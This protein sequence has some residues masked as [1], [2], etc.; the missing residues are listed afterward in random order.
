MELHQYWKIARRWWWL[1]ALPALAV[2]AYAL[3]T[4]RPPAPAYATTLRFTAGQP[5]ALTGS[6]NYDPNYY[7][8]LTSEYIVNALK[9]WA[10]TGAF[11]NAVSAELA[12]RGVSIPAGAVNASIAADNARSVLVLYLTWGDPAQLPALAEAATKVLQEQNAAAF[13]QLGGQAAQVVPLDAVG[14]GL[15]PPSLR[16]RFDLPLKIGLGLGVGLALA[17]AAHYFDPFVRDKEELE[18]MGLRVIGEIPKARK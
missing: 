3:A 2:G 14:I 9:D 13:P 12:A 11:A 10:R 15:V 7:R 8:W 1:I 18:E 17:F 6:P 16:I 5:A 4:R